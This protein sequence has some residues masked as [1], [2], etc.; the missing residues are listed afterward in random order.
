VAPELGFHGMQPQP[1]KFCIIKILS[2]ISKKLGKKV[3]ILFDN[4]NEII[5][6]CYWVCNRGGRSHFLRLRLRSCSKI[7]ESGSGS[8]SG[9]FS[10]LRIRL[11]FRLR[12]QSSIQPKFTHV[13]TSE[14]TTQTPA[15]AEIE[16]WLRIRVR[17]FLNYWLRVRVQVR[18]NN[19][20]SCW[21][22][23]R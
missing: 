8:E 16:K 22:R 1:Q 14:M 23:L 17:F 12:L 2:K 4:I 10:T 5:L 7:F 11:L 3:A 20:E 18:T 19:A 6:F 9:N 15:T 21:S 13:F